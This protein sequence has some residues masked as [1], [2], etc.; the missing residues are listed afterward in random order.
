MLLFD[1]PNA[2]IG[3]ALGAYSLLLWFCTARI[4]PLNEDAEQR[5]LRTEAV[6]IRLWVRV[7]VVCGTMLFL[8]AFVFWATGALEIGWLTA[9]NRAILG[10][11]PRVIGTG[12]L[13][14]IL[15]ALIP[16]VLLFALGTRPTELG[17]TP[18][19][20][21][22]W[23][24]AIPCLVLPA[25]AIA[26]SIARGHW[27]VGLL[28]MAIAHNL[29]SNGFTEEFFAR[30]M[31][32]SHLRAFVSKDWAL[33]G[34]AVLFALYHFGATPEEHGNVLM[35]VANVVS[36]N[37]PVAIALGLIA[38]RTRS[39]LLPTVLHVSLDTMFNSLA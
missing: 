10:A 27:T 30:G 33:F 37:L 18:T 29:L 13:N 3:V 21:R 9:L 11:M 36:E 16:G 4:V 19:A 35:I 22:T 7:A 23:L 12:L 14:F 32:L 39:L 2:W 17:L 28:L 26:F 15:I 6:G 20:K 1:R 31:I 5:V 8:C 24:A 25:G 38:L 34:Q